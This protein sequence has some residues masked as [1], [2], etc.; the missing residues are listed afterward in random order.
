M[1]VAVCERERLAFISVGT[2]RG[3][4]SILSRA[5]PPARHSGKLRRRHGRE[6][7]FSAAIAWLLAN[8]RRSA[9]PRYLVVAHLE[10][11]VAAARIKLSATSSRLS[12]CRV[13]PRGGHPLCIATFWHVG[14][15]AASPSLVRR[16]NRAQS[17]LFTSRT[18]C[19][20]PAPGNLVAATSARIRI[21]LTTHTLRASTR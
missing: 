16:I 9:H 10:E 14:G 4:T 1:C 20:M 12:V 13:T 19:A 11:D 6:R 5:A 17:R 2:D 15:V 7:C 8:P 3:G 18:A 21:P